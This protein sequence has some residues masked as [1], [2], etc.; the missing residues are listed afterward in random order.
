LR[1]EFWKAI[2]RDEALAP[3][4]DKTPTPKVSRV[5]RAHDAAGEYGN[6]APAAA[7]FAIAARI[8]SP[9][10]HSLR[11]RQ[12]GRGSAVARRRSVNRTVPRSPANSIHLRRDPARKRAAIASMIA[13]GNA[14]P[15]GFVPS[16]LAPSMR[17]THLP[18]AR[19]RRDR[20]S[21]SAYRIVIEAETLRSR[22]S[23]LHHA[24]AR[25]REVLRRLDR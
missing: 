5:H 18:P 24:R 12:C 20:G 19:A 4:P 8:S 9:R 23:G 16:R 11:Y 2:A 10:A 17:Q 15:P 21:F 1:P 3:P 6:P 13:A 22:I 25:A 14:N 7:S